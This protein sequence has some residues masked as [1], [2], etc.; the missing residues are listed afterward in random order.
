M[1]NN[2]QIDLVLP[3]DHLFR[4]MI[5]IPDLVLRFRHL[6]HEVLANTEASLALM[7]RQR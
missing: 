2:N 5:E 1:S 4:A 3:D 7:Q 6:S